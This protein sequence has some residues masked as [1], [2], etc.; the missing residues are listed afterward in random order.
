[1]TH[2]W[3]A[4]GAASAPARVRG[5]RTIPSRVN[6]VIEACAPTLRA[7]W[8]AQVSKMLDWARQLVAFYGE[9]LSV[10]AARE[11]LEYVLRPAL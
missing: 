4:S 10:E 5:T 3:A 11:G 8:D 7:A 1:M 6:V 2:Q 9:T